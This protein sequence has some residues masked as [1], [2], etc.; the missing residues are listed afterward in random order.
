MIIDFV[1]NK[2]QIYLHHCTFY[3]NCHENIQ[4]NLI[5]FVKLQYNYKNIKKIPL[6]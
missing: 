3:T 6:T 4:L 1:R 5:G 2:S